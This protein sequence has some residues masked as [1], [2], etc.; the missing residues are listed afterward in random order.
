MSTVPGGLW[1]Q[2]GAG[3]LVQSCGPEL[4]E[5]LHQ[6]DLMIEVKRKEWEEEYKKAGNRTNLAIKKVFDFGC[7]LTFFDL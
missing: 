1:S 3:E 7:F 4:A 6:V 5:V 2:L